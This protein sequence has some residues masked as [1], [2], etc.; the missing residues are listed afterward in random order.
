MFGRIM[1]EEESDASIA[2]LPT[3]EEKE[4]RRKLREQ[5]SPKDAVRGPDGGVVGC[6]LYIVPAWWSYSSS[7][8][9]SLKP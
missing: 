3:D 1:S 2:S 5:V 8:Q 7:Q 4:E 9:A 6:T